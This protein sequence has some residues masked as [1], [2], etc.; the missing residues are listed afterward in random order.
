MANYYLDKLNAECLT[1]TLRYIMGEE[2]NTGITHESAINYIAATIAN[3]EIELYND[4][5]EDWKTHREYIT[6][7]TQITRKLN[8]IITPWSED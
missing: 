6:R 5:H 1:Q 2:Q 8:K 3:L 4:C 7:R